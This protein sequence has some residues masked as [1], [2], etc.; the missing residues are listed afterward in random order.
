[1]RSRWSLAIAGFVLIVAGGLLAQLTQT[2]GG[3]RIQ[4][5]RFAGAKGNTMSALLY[6]PPN[7]TA[8]NPA[9][10]ILAVHGYI[11]SRETQDGFAIEFARRGYVVL[12]LDQT[13]H[14][15]SDPPAFADHEP[16]PLCLRQNI[17]MSSP[18]RPPHTPSPSRAS[19]MGRMRAG[20]LAPTDT[21][22][23]LEAARACPDAWYRVQA[24]A[25]VAEHADPS[26]SILK[27]AS[28]E[29]QS[30]HDAYRTVAVMAWPLGLAFKQGLL[31]FAE[32]E[33]EKCLALASR[34]EPPGSQ[35][36]ALQ[37]L[38]GACFAVDPRHAEP[39]WSRILEL[40]H[41]DRSW[42]AARLYLHIAEVQNSRNP[43]A[44]AAVIRAMAP[45]K[46]RAWLERRFGLA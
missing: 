27:E 6:I 45:G 46:A 39:V 43:D 28:R 9:P 36:Y 44:A 4:D 34:I 26:L 24:L 41:P 3:I 19:V 20:Q 16:Q 1:M 10:G 13:G 11:N 15:Y 2:S 42:R 17:I 18:Q 32:P 31:S 37:T 8:Q 38:W 21:G 14:G 33:L 7:A 25:S 12:D 40:C 23:A 30:C 29:A 22:K 5:I 35:A